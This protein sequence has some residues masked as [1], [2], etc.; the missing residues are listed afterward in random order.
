MLVSGIRTQYH[1]YWNALL[2]T[3]I[4]QHT[5]L[6]RKTIRQRPQVSKENNHSDQANHHRQLPD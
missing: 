4:E 5:G 3:E 2:L 1:Y 6:T